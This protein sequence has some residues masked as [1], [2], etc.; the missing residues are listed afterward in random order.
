MALNIDVKPSYYRVLSP[1]GGD[2]T[3]II[4]T[5]LTDC[6]SSGGG[7]V[8]LLPGEYLVTTTESGYALNLTGSVSLE[9]SGMNASWLKNT[10][11]S[12]DT[13]R[14]TSAVGAKI[15]QLGWKAASGVTRASG[16]VE[17]SIASANRSLFSHLSFL[18]LDST[19]CIL[20][21]GFGL[22]SGCYIEHVNADGYKYGIHVLDAIDLYID[23]L[24]ASPSNTDDNSIT[25]LLEGKCE[26]I[27][28]RSSDLV[29][30][31][32][33]HGTAFK[34]I[35]TGNGSPWS[36]FI[37][38]VYFDNHK[39]PIDLQAGYAWDITAC[40]FSS[41]A[42]GTTNVNIG[43][44]VR[45]VCFH[46]SQIYPFG[47]NSKAIVNAGRNVQFIGTHIGHCRPSDTTAANRPIQM[48]ASA[49]GWL[50]D[51]V[52]YDNTLILDRY[53]D[54][55]VAN[56]AGVLNDASGGKGRVRNSAFL[57]SDGTPS[58]LTES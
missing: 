8:K 11:T 32:A 52:V 55:T 25:V 47:V 41:G 20:Y 12:G 48:S 46:A 58:Y 50:L 23:N 7:I 26:A 40:H 18:N 39:Y 31:G 4:Q 27:V 33:N 19:T 54:G 13:L 28:L 14:L 30:E 16:A 21:T 22:S 15:S 5:A 10:S 51:G 53:F 36:N 49:A 35:A 57:A 17:L 45:S 38:N 2:D 34:A 3:D 29:N 56:A 9:G 6:N 37:S 1:S 44:S 42:D 43:S 24:V